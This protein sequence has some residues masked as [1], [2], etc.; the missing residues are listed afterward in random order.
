M[1][2]ENIKV[3][4]SLEVYI[5]DQVV[6]SVPNLVVTTGK[7]FVASRIESNTDTVMTHMAIGTGT[8]AAASGN[9]SLETEVS[10]VALSSTSVSGSV[11]TYAC[12]FAAGSPSG[13]SAVTEAAIFDSASGG[14]MLCRTVFPVV[15]KGA[16][17]SLTI[18]WTVDVS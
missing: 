18:V 4:G 3:T 13:S 15:N 5:N 6:R 14:T 10:R 11:V 17:D 12:V 16:S 8:T 1:H 7:A 2:K 9:T